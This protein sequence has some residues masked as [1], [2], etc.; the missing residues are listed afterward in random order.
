[1]M[2]QINPEKILYTQ[3][4]DEGVVYNLEKNEYLTLNE[5]Y[6]KILQGVEQGLTLDELVVALLAEYDVSE[7]Q[8]HSEVEAAL[9]EMEGMGY[10]YASPGQVS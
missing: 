8:C 4:G 6:F 3:L 7:E 10:I 1:M 9:Q 2:Y 5:T